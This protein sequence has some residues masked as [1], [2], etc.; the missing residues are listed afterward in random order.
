MPSPDDFTLSVSRP[1]FRALL[2]TCALGTREIDVYAEAL[3]DSP[4]YDWS[5]VLSQPLHWTRPLRGMALTDVEAQ[6]LR[7]AL[8]RRASLDGLRIRWDE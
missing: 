7:T 6:T 4:D 2:I 8:M 3:P 5:I 1:S